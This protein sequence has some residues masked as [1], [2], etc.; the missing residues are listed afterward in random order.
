M[1]A[2]VTAVGLLSGGLD[3]ELAIRLCQEQGITVIGLSCRHPFHA[4]PPPGGAPYPERVA[5]ELGIELVR[6]DVT[7]DFLAMIKEPPHGYGKR[8][9]PCIDCR[10]L[11]LR[12]G[13]RLMQVRGAHFLVTGEVLGQRPMSQRRDAMNAIDR[14]SGLRG[15]ILRPLS[16]QLLNPTLAEE[17]GLV[18]RSRLLAISG[19]S[20]QKQLALA[21]KLGLQEFSS[22]GGGCLLTMEDF[23][24]KMKDLISHRQ[25]LQREDVELLKVG[26]HFRLSPTAMIAMGKDDAENQKLIALALES[27][28]IIAARDAPGP[29][30]L[31]RGLAS[32]PELQLAG[33]I[34]G[35][36]MKKGQGPMVF[37][38][39]PGRGGE[40]RIL[41]GDPLSA[42]EVESYRI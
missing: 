7:A 4:S 15:Q 17:K 9:N 25:D 19:R 31:V 35:R 37:T 23:A 18:D 39:K 1:S 42:T 20:R 32:E 16:A 33:R 2:N 38:L 28:L 6:P 24:R 21:Q 22:P 40:E 29:L 26:R 8:L 41:A 36:Y 3:S 34:T 14:D 30:T 12:E 5:R 10:I 27:D 11:Y 13:A